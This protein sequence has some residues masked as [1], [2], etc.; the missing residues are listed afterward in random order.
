MAGYVFLLCGAG[1]SWQSKPSHYLQ[2]KQ[3]TKQ[4]YKQPKK[5][6]WW[7]HFLTALGYDM[8]EPSIL[9]SDSQGSGS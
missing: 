5:A 9:R 2:S 4:Q 3:K 1:I 7:R 6:I 8:S